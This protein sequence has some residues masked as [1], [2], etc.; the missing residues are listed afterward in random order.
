MKQNIKCIFPWMF[1]LILAFFA[2]C[3][4]G[5]SGSSD[6][7][8]PSTTKTI[9]FISS[10]SPSNNSVYLE[11]VSTNNEE[12][13]LALKVKGGAS[14][15]A[16]ALEINFDGGKIQFISG[17]EGTF[18]NQQGGSGVSFY[19]RMEDGS[20]EVLLIGVSRRAGS[21]DVNGDGIL[22]QIVLKALNPQTNTAVN[23]NV[24]NS[25]LQLSNGT[26]ISGTNFLGGNLTYQ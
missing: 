20:K 14:V 12:I 5:N 25:A 21:A 16:A 9:S 18:L 1:A 22:C 10:G 23:F 17:A 15:F 6:P 4:P 26:N 11:Q 3:K 7:V 24:T 8:S 2:G 19:S 13:I